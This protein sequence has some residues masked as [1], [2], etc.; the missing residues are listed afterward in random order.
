MIKQAEKPD[1]CRKVGF[2]LQGFEP[3]ISNKSTKALGASL[4]LP[5]GG[6]NQRRVGIQ[7]Y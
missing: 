7:I 1:L 3:L 5:M 6:Q 2:E 4:E